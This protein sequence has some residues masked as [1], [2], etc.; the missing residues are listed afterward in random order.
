M[1]KEVLGYTKALSIKLQGRYVDVVRAFKDVGLVLEVLR[2][3]REDVDTFHNRIYTT[4][5]SIARK[6]NIEESRPRT[7]GRQQHR[8]NAPSSSTSVSVSSPYRPL[9]TYF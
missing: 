5:L 2:S 3:V 9:I 4:A 6:L 8:G 1:T 7:T